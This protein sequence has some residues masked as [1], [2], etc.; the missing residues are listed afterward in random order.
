MFD[1]RFPPNFNSLNG[2]VFAELPDDCPQAYW[3]KKGYDFLS[4]QALIQH[5][6]AN[7]TQLELGGSAY[8]SFVPSFFV[9][10]EEGNPT[11][12]K[13]VEQMGQALGAILLTLQIG[14]EANRLANPSKDKAYWDYWSQVEQVYIAGGL[15]SGKAG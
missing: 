7:L 14:T 5:I 9:R 15:T 11:A 3:G 12:T 4:L 2:L 8:S 6:Q 1:P 13:I 10:L